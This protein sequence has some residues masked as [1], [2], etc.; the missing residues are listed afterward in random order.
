MVAQP[1][2]WAFLLRSLI[3]ALLPLSLQ[4]W[5]LGSK[6]ISVTFVLGAFRTEWLL[7]IISAENMT[8]SK[9]RAQ[10]MTPCVT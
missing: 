7:D 6:D 8:F 4:I 10:L 2:I 3:R 1:T 9:L 5:I